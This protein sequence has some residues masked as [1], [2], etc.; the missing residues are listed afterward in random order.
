MSD[1][2]RQI[3]GF[4]KEM[5]NVTMARCVNVVCKEDATEE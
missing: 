1:V 5:S 2:V 3:S 4:E